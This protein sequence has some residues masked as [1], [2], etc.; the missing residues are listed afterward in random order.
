M[1]ITKAKPTDYGID[2]DYWNVGSIQEDFK[3]KGAHVTMYGWASVDARQANKQPIAAYTFEI[4]GDLYKADVTRPIVYG[5][6]KTK[7]EWKGAEDA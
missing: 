1:A 6:A 5:L 2:A 7:P 4:S 3:G